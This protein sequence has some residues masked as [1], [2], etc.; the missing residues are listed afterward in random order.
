MTSILWADDDADELFR[1]LPKL[2]SVKGCDLLAT[3]SYNDALQELDNARSNGTSRFG[4]L[5]VDVILPRKRH[6]G[7]LSRD[8]GIALARRAVLEFGI[9]RVS[10]FTVVPYAELA[11]RIDQLRREHGNA[12]SVSCFDKT[13]LLERDLVSEIVSSFKPEESRGS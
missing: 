1:H 13:V 7:T 12:L 2:F 4:G 8:L 9:S 3:I 11:A 6:R 5:L 10:F